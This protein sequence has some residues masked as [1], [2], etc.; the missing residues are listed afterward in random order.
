MSQAAVLVTRAAPL[1]SRVRETLACGEDEALVLLNAYAWDADALE[2]QIFVDGARQRVGV[3]G[4][5]D[6][7]AQLPPGAAADSAFECA[8]S[9]EPARYADADACACGPWFSAAAWR[10]HLEAAM[11]NPNAALSARCPASGGD[12]GCREVVRPRLWRKF[13]PPALFERYAAFLAR[14]FSD[15]A[16]AVRGCPAPG[17]DGVVVCDGPPEVDV[18]CA[19]GH[20]FC[21]ACRAAAHRPA[22]CKEVV[23]WN[24]KQVDD[25]GNAKWLVAHTKPCPKCK[26]S[27]EKNSGCNHMT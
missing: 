22:S 6:P 17:C 19:A 15:K 10:G 11:A 7:P 16:R 1:V 9:L 23:R 21:F 8:V 26:R 2:E 12:G 3:S 18:E 4:G 5:P 14:S 20:A 24:K 13:L 25:G 27:I